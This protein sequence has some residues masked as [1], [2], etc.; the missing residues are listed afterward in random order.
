MQQNNS[1][2][3][4]QGSV[5]AALSAA[6]A[7]A[8]A[9]FPLPLQS[10]SNGPPAMMG[11]SLRF[12]GEDGGRSLAEMAQRDL[13]A[14]L[15]LLADRAQYI[16]GASG[17]AIALRRDGKND[18]LCRASSGSN[19]PE[20]GALLSTEFG[21]SGES[22]R[23]RQALRC[24]DAERDVR[25]NHE[26]CRQMGIASVVVM[27][28]V[29]DDEVL[30]V[31]ELFS[32]RANAFGAR[33]VSAV[34][35][36]SE[37]VETAV[38]LAH[39]TERLP[40][41]LKMNSPAETQPS[42]DQV[43]AGEVVADIVLPAPVSEE[44]ILEEQPPVAKD[45]LGESKNVAAAVLPKNEESVAAPQKPLPSKNDPPLTSQTPEKPA[46]QMRSA[47]ASVTPTPP[48]S[49]SATGLGTTPSADS[50]LTKRNLFWSAAENPAVDATK[51]DDADRS[52]V[53]PVL[54]G[55]RQCEAC[56]FPVSAGRTFCVECEEKK[57][58]GQLKVEKT[59]PR[60]VVVAASPAAEKAAPEA[61]K[62]EALTHA[63]SSIAE[64]DGMRRAAV[65]PASPGTVSVDSKAF[66]AAANAPVAVPQPIAAP[67]PFAVRPAEKESKPTLPA[68]SRPAVPET[69]AAAEVASPEFVLSAAMDPSQSWLA[70]NKYIVGVLLMVIVTIAAIFL[71]RS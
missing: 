57:W 65:K 56:G 61:T 9:N 33:D 7:E 50:L 20:L 26:V 55:L 25:V 14:A 11:S 54:R 45:I 52:H 34:Q 58:K 32:G 44:S 69:V 1:N 12:P 71:L 5:S 38:R 62:N 35:R 24:D 17:A 43:L 16:T 47:S 66:A 28:V 49:T 23:T 3:N 29:N 2:R 19:A 37:M 40:D 8:N 53:P 63:T 6:R 39:V 30:G 42:D 70:A 51:T 46:A 41:R 60:P 21:L 68:D 64:L 67:M 10:L 36:L 31:F 15:Q 13:D 48:L 22:V 18:M 27:P 4:P 59:A